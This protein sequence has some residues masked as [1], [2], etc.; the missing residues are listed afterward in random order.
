[1]PSAIIKV[2]GLGT[3]IFN[4]DFFSIKFSKANPD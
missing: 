4:T 3:D 2:E 1:M